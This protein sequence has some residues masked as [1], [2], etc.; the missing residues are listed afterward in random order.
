MK[1][2]VINIDNNIFISQFNVKLFRA[3][4]MKDVRNGIRQVNPNKR[5]I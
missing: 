5:S 2:L 4:T 3:R 1:T